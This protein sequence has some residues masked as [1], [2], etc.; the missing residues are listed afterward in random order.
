MKKN[1]M[2][3]CWSNGFKTLPTKDLKESFETHAPTLAKWIKMSSMSGVEKS[4]LSSRDHF[5][6]LPR[7]F[8]SLDGLRLKR[9]GALYLIPAHAAG[10]LIGVRAALEPSGLN[11]IF[12]PATRDAGTVIAIGDALAEKAHE[13]RG[14][15]T[16]YIETGR[17]RPSTMKKIAV[18]F[19]HLAEIKTKLAKE[20]GG[21]IKSSTKEAFSEVEGLILKETK[22]IDGLEGPTEKRKQ[23]EE[24]IPEIEIAPSPVP[25]VE[26]YYP[27][28]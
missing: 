6:I 7:I 14:A 16:A 9:Q 20:F 4:I 13:A 10:S 2:I 17:A 21:V 18:R 27:L 25:V 8:D 3:V 15:I 19:D 12:S 5:V 28:H 24:A 22:R 26:S 23:K 11:L 1:S